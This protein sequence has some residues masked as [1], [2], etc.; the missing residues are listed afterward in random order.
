MI[1]EVNINYNKT[2]EDLVETASAVSRMYEAAHEDMETPL[3]VASIDLNKIRA[4]DAV[5]DEEIEQL[6]EVYF[7]KVVRNEINFRGANLVIS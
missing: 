5:L 4:A 1:L 3:F 7:N 6:M 2:V